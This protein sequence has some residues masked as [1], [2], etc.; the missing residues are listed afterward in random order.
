MTGEGH[1]ERDAAEKHAQQDEIDAE[2]R[3][4]RAEQDREAD[5]RQTAADERER[6]AD[7]R[8]TAADERE[9]RAD[10]REA[11]IDRR[12][13]E[14][15]QREAEADQRD[16]EE[17]NR[18]LDA[19][20]RNESCGGHFREEYQTDEGE[21]LRDDKHFKYVAAWE[22]LKEGDFKLHKEELEYEEIEVKQRNYK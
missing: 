16:L 20:N 13:A 9:R 8:Q 1:D 12:E 2:T 15:D 4:S 19:L 22:Y 7:R 17:A 3:R 6:Q 11:E 5:R 14:A 21:C 18:S 10:R